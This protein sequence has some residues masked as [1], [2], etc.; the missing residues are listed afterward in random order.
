MPEVRANLAFAGGAKITGLPA[1]AANGEAVT[2]EQLNAAVEGVAWKDSSRVSTQGNVSLASPGATIDGITMVGGDRVLVRA[3]TAQA[4]NGIYVWNGAAVAMTRAPDCDLAAELEQA[5]TTVEE[6]T[7]AGVSFR[8]TSVNFTLGAGAVSWTV[9]GS[10][11]GAASETSA[12]VAELATQAET[13]AG[14]DDARIVTPLKLATSAFAKRKF[15]ADFGDGSATQFDVTHNFNTEDVI[16]SVR[17]NS[18]D[19]DVLCDI[20]RFSVNVVRINVASA[21]GVNAL[22]VVIVG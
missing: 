14:T 21:P 9:F 7:N 13:D 22:R 11:A 18:D 17:R 5:I 1:A 6:G 15:A 8:Q 3:Q 16:V 20:R 19:A 10:G 12:G 4:E 2:F